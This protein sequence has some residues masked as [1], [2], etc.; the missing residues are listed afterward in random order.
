[1]DFTQA[2]AILVPLVM[3]CVFATLLY[4]DWLR[5]HRLG[6]SVGF[7]LAT[8]WPLALLSSGYG[9]LTKRWAQKAVLR[10]HKAEQE[11]LRVVDNVIRLFSQTDVADWSK[12]VDEFVGRV[13]KMNVTTASVAISGALAY[14]FRKNCDNTKELAQ[15]NGF[16]ERLEAAK[17]TTQNYEREISSLKARLAA[18]EHDVA[19]YARKADSSTKHVEQARQLLI[20][21]IK[22]WSKVIDSDDK[23]FEQVFV[24][25]LDQQYKLI[26]DAVWPK[27]NIY[28]N[29][30]AELREKRKTAAEKVA[31]LEN[32]VAQY[33]TELSSFKTT[34]LY[35]DTPLVNTTLLSDSTRT[36]VDQMAAGDTR[37]DQTLINLLSSYGINLPRVASYVKLLLEQVRHA[38]T[39][40]KNSTVTERN[41]AWMTA[42]A[43][44]NS[45]LAGSYDDPAKV[46]AVCDV[47]LSTVD[48]DISKHLT[49]VLNN[50]STRLVEATKRAHADSKAWDLYENQWPIPPAGF[51]TAK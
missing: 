15:L 19:G 49:P 34:R 50:M 31:T 37:A 13:R 47:A 2:F 28:T 5:H 35:Y 20:N 1:M 29:A 42:L 21:T 51:V 22:S 43:K 48:P 8:V 11:E 16:K 4:Q 3:Y 25:D 12:I 23:T 14:L 10:K 30:L 32:K 38:V 40:T 27:E 33:E 41:Q 18:A 46:K 44:L 17:A 24:T 9:A 26:P 45:S 6:K 36:L 7:M 39:D